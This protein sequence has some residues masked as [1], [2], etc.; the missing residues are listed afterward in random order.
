MH[1]RFYPSHKREKSKALALLLS[2]SRLDYELIRAE[3][4]KV[5]GT[6][7]YGAHEDPIIEIDGEIFVN[8]NPQALR[9]M[10]SGEIAPDA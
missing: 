3:D 9:K 1:I 7:L 5:A 6:R 2:D 10:L 8:P 4:L